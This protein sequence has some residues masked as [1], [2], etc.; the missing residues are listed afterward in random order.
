MAK[1]RNITGDTLT[2]GASSAALGGVTVEA[3]KTFDVADELVLEEGHTCDAEGHQ[4]HSPTPA[5]TLDAVRAGRRPTKV[6][7]GH[8]PAD[9]LPR[10]THPSAR[11][12][13]DTRSKPC[14]SPVAD[15]VQR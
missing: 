9:R 8:R 14:R 7:A 10:V 1:F 11:W 5:S 2:V 12:A 6:R 13:H 4:E 15:W 3:G